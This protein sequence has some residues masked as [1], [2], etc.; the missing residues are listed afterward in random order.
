MFLS[1]RMFEAH[2]QRYKGDD[3]L[4]E[5]ERSASDPFLP[6][7]QPCATLKTNAVHIFL[8]TCSG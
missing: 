4:G 7:Q 3:P 5:W 6:L 2:M 1:F 8:V